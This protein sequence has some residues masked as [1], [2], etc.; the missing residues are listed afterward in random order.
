VVAVEGADTCVSSYTGGV[1]AVKG[2]DT[3]VVSW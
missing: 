3:G 2:A 1:V